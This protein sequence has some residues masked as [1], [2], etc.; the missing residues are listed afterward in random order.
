MPS[1]AASGSLE[2]YKTRFDIENA[3]TRNVLKVLPPDKLDYRPH[4]RSPSTGQIAWTI[5]RG[6]FIRIDMASRGASDVLLESHPG[7]EEILD[8]FED[9]SRRHAGQLET[10]PEAA[11]EK[12][13]HLRSGGHVALE[14]PAGDIVWL[15]HFDEIHHRGQLST[16]LR[17]MAAK[18][19]SIYGAS[20]RKNPVLRPLFP[21]KSLRC[22]IEEFA[23]FLIQSLGGD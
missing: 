6:L 8:R 19:P 11:W 14:R 15:F 3:L 18:V 23:A 16:Y 20:G 9:A 22:A 12:I 17:P 2:F 21:A 13:G 7:F 1:S 10:W 5:L 4:E